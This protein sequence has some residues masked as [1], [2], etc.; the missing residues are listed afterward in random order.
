MRDADIARA[1]QEIRT[2]GATPVGLVVMLYDSALHSLHGALRA[3]EE[4]KIEQR[5]AELN[6]VLSILG[7]LQASLN[8]ERGGD[9]ARHIGRFYDVARGKILEANITAS[10]EILHQLAEI[11]FSLRQAWQ[12]VEQDVSKPAPDGSR[13]VAAPSSAASR[14]MGESRYLGS[15]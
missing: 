5:T 6:R 14:E 9:V 2:R 15:A 10:G 13:P 1:Y 3:L 7:E 8:H 12:Q 4:N 11:F